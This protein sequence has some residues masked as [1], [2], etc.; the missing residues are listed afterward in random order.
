MK[1]FHYA[2]A[3]AMLIALA[4]PAVGAN[5]DITSSSK[6]ETKTEQKNDGT[7]EHKEDATRESNDAAGTDT[8]V[9]SNVK[10]EEKPNGDASKTVKTKTTVDPQGMMNQNVT[11]TS[12]KMKK[13]NGKTSVQHKKTVNGK[14]IED[15]E[16]E[17]NPDTQ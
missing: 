7:Y 4:G 11:E 5:D 17:N 14:V 12:Y 15:N 8:K 9:E 16:Q 2:L 6:V 1:M 3:A 10:L 13:E